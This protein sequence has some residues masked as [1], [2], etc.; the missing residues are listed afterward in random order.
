MKTTFDTTWYVPDTR[1]VAEAQLAAENAEFLARFALGYIY[2]VEFASGI[3]KVG[4][5]KAPDDR[6][7]YH[8]LLARVHGG[9]IRSTWVS[10]RLVAYGDAERDL[11]RLCARRGDLV[12]GREYFR[13]DPREARILASI[14][15]QNR[16]QVDA[17]PAELVALLDGEDVAS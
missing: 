8:A 10:R 15:E 6:A 9:E 1:A 17:L 16:V 13:M 12:A 7:A 3:V 11:I 2:V 4:R 14:V 5:A